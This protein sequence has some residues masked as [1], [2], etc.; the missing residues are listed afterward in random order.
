M[1]GLSFVLFSTAARVAR[2]FRSR[3]GDSSAAWADRPDGRSVFLGTEQQCVR[4]ALQHII[5]L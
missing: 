3:V 1:G 2:D 4:P 5:V